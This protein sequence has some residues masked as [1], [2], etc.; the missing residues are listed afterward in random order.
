M[1]PS[2]IALLR[3][4]LELEVSARAGFVDQACAGYPALREE[5]HQ[6]LAMDAGEDTVLDGGIDQLAAALIVTAAGSGDDE[7]CDPLSAGAL[8]GPW[9]ILR[10]LGSGGMGSVWLA[11]RADGAFAQRVALKMIKPGMDSAAVLTAF[12]RERDLLARLEH[13]GIAHLIDG[14]ID[15]SGRPWYAMRHVEGLTLD[16]WLL[17]NP[18]LKARLS[19]FVTLCRTVA[20]AHRQLVVHRDIKPGN[21]IVQD[22]GAPCLL[23]FGIAKILQRESIDTIATIDHFAS[24]GYAAPEQI[25]GGQISTATDVYGL[26]AMLFEML[27]HCR[28][29]NLHRGGDIPTRPSQARPASAD[30][31]VAIPVKQMKGDLDAITMR[32]LAPDPARR[33]SSAEALAD[34]VQRYLDGQPVTARPDGFGYRFSR[35]IRRNRL[36]ATGL[37]LAL[38]AMFAGT[39][40]SLW[41]AQRATEEAQRANTVKAYLISLFDAGRTNSGGTDMLNQRVIDML[42][43]SV[44]RLKQDLHDQPELR[45]EIYTVLVEIYDANH[46]GER[47]MALARERVAMADAAF[48]NGDA[49]VAPALLLLAGVLLNHEQLDE[50]PALLAR[51]GSLLD[52]AGDQDSLS[53]ALWLHYSGSFAFEQAMERDV[54]PTEALGFYSRAADLMRRHF[55]DSDELLVTLLKM[56]EVASWGHDQAVTEAAIAEVRERTRRRYGNTHFYLTQVSTIQASSWI[57]HGRVEEGLALIRQIHRDVVHFSGE[58]HNDVLAL[59][60]HEF[61]ALLALG[62]LDE[63]DALLQEAEAWRLRHHPDVAYMKDALENMRARIERARAD[64]SAP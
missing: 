25:N 46:Q 5:V 23:D 47:S 24:P 17:Q 52:A 4:A 18:A 9:R 12:N 45:D 29:S 53:R 8:V 6:L 11:E 2:R 42:D 26:G 3:Q 22:D 20:H 50:V 13:P 14:G 19:L 40:I 7:S 56:A 57:D 35:W 30:A 58:Q 28:Y 38:V 16:Q 55:P 21:V 51:A 48:G 44:A 10:K 1:K 41:Q 39:G 63:A 61:L 15:V 31:R 59:R 60:Y 36:A 33:Y 37:L 64:I 32:A 54:L 62:R 27:T 34:D 43:A 49:R